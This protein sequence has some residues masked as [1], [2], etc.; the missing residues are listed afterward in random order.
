M[1]MIRSLASIRSLSLFGLAVAASACGEEAAPLDVP[2]PRICSPNWDVVFSAG[3][4]FLPADTASRPMKIAGDRVYV[5]VFGF[6][7]PSDDG[8]LSFPVGGGEVTHVQSADTSPYWIEGDRL[9]Y[10][11]LRTLYSQPLTGGEPQALFTVGRAE[12]E[13]RWFRGPWTLDPDFLYWLTDD[14]VQ[15]KI[16]HR[17]RAGGEDR[18]LATLPDFSQLEDGII[19]DIEVVGDQLYL[20][21]ANGLWTLPKNGGPV[22][23]V[24]AVAPNDEWLGIASDG[25]TLWQRTVS[26]TLQDVYDVYSLSAQDG[27]T[28]S[29]WS[30]TSAEIFPTQAW[31]DGAGG[32]YVAGLERGTDGG[33]HLTVSSLDADGTLTRLACDPVVGSRT[34]HGA[35]TRDGLHLLVTFDNN[36]TYWE[37]ASVSRQ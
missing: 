1:S 31:D 13:A 10:V 35:A 11:N 19:S 24:E 4:D 27:R 9:L 6:H 16:W 30:G 17:A 18:E 25:T 5:S 12:D 15:V 3:Q 29:V 33:T 20:L 14:F 8:L 22:Q 23:K 7:S 36:S 32:W 2:D 21:G 28:T 26:R 34:S 37:I